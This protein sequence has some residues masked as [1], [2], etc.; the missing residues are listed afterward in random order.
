ML[1]QMHWHPE[2]IPWISKSNY[3]AIATAILRHMCEYGLST[4]V[5]MSNQYKR[6]I[7]LLEQPCVKDLL[8]LNRVG[9]YFGNL[10]RNQK[11]NTKYEKFIRAKHHN[12]LLDYHSLFVEH[13]NPNTSFKFDL[14]AVLRKHTNNRRAINPNKIC[15]FAIGTPC[16]GNRIFIDMLKMHFFQNVTVVSRDMC[17][18]AVCVG[19][20]KY[21]DIADFVQMYK[22]YKAGKVLSELLRKCDKH[23][24]TESKF[25]NAKSNLSKTQVDWNVYRQTSP[26]ATTLPKI[27]VY[28]PLTDPIP[29]ISTL[30]LNL[31]KEKIYSAMNDSSTFLV[32]DTF[33]S[34]FPM[35]IDS[36]S[37]IPHELTKFFHV[38]VHTQSYLKRTAPSIAATL[39]EQIE[40]CGP[41]GL[42]N[43]LHPDG[44]DNYRNKIAFTSLSAEDETN[45]SLPC[46]TFTS[47]FRPHLVAV[48][49]RTENGGYIGYDETIECLKRLSLCL[50]KSD[51][52]KDVK[53][54]FS[55][56]KDC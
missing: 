21:L 14:P 5:S 24:L 43:P 48:C 55:D 49:T 20:Y 42:N 29:D 10:I 1:F 19:M 25:V 13:L 8:C 54:V 12:E 33:L 47:K 4:D 11:N 35:V 16:A 22:I 39:D 53:S 28:N 34:S 31:F 36:R 3:M 26:N 45:D 27:K 52:V 50:I 32:I 46:S 44:F 2:M 17:I 56:A 40:I 51:V 7:L 38:H 37:Q 41:Y 9:D 30:L 18:A 15:L 6:D 23:N